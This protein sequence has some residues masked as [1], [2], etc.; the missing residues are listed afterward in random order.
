M[1]EYD[2]AAG[3][4]LQAAREAMGVS[5]GD[6][7]K[8]LGWE[9]LL[10][11]ALESGNTVF[12]DE[13]AKDVQERYNINVA[14]LHGEDAPMFLEKETPAP[15]APRRFNFN[16]ELT[17]FGIENLPQSVGRESREDSEA[18]AIRRAR[19]R[20][21]DDCV[22]QHIGHNSNAAMDITTKALD[23]QGAAELEFFEQG[24]MFGARMVFNLLAG[25]RGFLAS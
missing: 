15:M 9:R 18:S 25:K 17:I 21:F 4:R 7:A 12:S 22:M 14:W 16:E 8:E 3:V 23:M 24:M 19:E 5:Q 6:M 2:V 11:R 10:V 20:E 1:G 13:M